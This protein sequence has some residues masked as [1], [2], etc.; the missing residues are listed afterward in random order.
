MIGGLLVLVA[1]VAVAPGDE[2]RPRVDDRAAYE[3]AGKAVG[4]DAQAHVRLALWCE[5]H[6]M[7][8]ERIKHLAAA[9]ANVPAN[10]LARGLMGLVS[11]N[12]K[13]ERPDDV[14]REAKDDAGRKALMQEYLERR[15]KTPETVDGQFKLASWC[16]QN[17]LKPQAAAHFQRVVRL[18]PKREAAWRHLGFKKLGGRW[19][20]PELVAAEKARA[21]EQQ[22]ADKHWK[23]ILE[24][25]R[26]GLQAKSPTR[27]AEAEQ[28][29]ARITERD[30]VPMVWAVFGRGEPSMQ[31]VAV[32][33][34]GQIDDGSASRALAMLA[35]FGGSPE[36]RRLAT[37][38]LR[39]RDVREFASLLIGML[40][41]PIEYELKRV[42]GPG[43]GGELLIKVQGSAPNLKRLYSPPA[44]PT[45]GPRTGDYLVYDGNGLP[46]LLRPIGLYTSPMVTLGQLQ[47]AAQ[48]YPT[49]PA[50]NLPNLLAGS[51]LAAQGRKLGQMLV[52][53][54][55][56][57]NGIA[58]NVGP[59][60]LNYLYQV[61]LH[62]PALNPWIPPNPGSGI[63]FQQSVTN[64][65]PVGQMALEAQKTAFVAGRQLD[66]DVAAIDEYNQGLAQL[67]DRVLPVLKDVS[68]LDLD[69]KPLEW[70]K[71]YISQIGY[72]LNQMQASEK[73]TVVEDVPL[74]YQPQPVPI[75]QIFSP[76]IGIRVM[77]C[78]GA[79]TLVRTLTGLEP[80][81]ALKVGDQVLTQSTR[82]GALAYKPIVTV[83]HN[84]PSKT[85]R[86][87]LGGETIVSSEF[88]RFW[89]AGQGW[90]M[91]RDIKDGD[92]IR[93]LDGP[94]AVTSVERS[95]VVLVYNLD[96]ADDND[97]FVGRVGALVHDNTLPDL[98]EKPFDAVGP[99]T[100]KSEPAR[101]RSML[102][103]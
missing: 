93:T 87:K 44:G 2:P 24:R 1:L 97:F 11:Y 79:G 21:Q 103:R 18:D 50:S 71:W 43:Q 52:N 99:L 60:G 5:A 83:H 19:V 74:A 51:G 27:R 33:V 61:G 17:G 58:G 6:G 4:N 34:L 94:S 85:F 96:V 36:V 22:K 56:H 78:F 102:G 37:E 65:I 28:A 86:V 7:T 41:E 95:D 100:S 76:A 89:K 90:V 49:A 39:R 57:V 64:V 80:I 25:Y 20:K 29:L 12:G 47:A 72:R 9:V 16:E 75:G 3:A 31:K 101:A 81:E 98:R 82:T 68:G 40:L 46:V 35:V 42:G 48:M 84:P 45:I 91:A 92:L 66:S 14:S 54:S 26:S 53:F 63:V 30:A 62:A 88:H 69:A 77:S 55:E 59:Y 70:K 10:A 15:A 38:T 8:A 32:Q 13:W 23:P 73:S 67:N